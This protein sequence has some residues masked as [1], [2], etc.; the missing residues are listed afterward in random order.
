MDPRSDSGICKTPAL[1]SECVGRHRQRS[2]CKAWGRVTQAYH[3][4]NHAQQG[5]CPWSLRSRHR[6]IYGHGVGFFIIVTSPHAHACDR[7]PAQTITQPAR[8]T[9]T[10]APMFHDRFRTLHTNIQSGT[11][12]GAAREHACLHSRCAAHAHKYRL[13]YH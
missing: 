1:C 13:T 7:S 10:H 12:L 5:G 3:D 6:I 4:S 2:T 8:M 9:Y 11:V